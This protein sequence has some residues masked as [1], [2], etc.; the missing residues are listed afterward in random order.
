MCRPPFRILLAN[1]FI[2]EDSTLQKRV[3]DIFAHKN[4]PNV[5]TIEDYSK[6]ARSTSFW[7][8]MTG[9]T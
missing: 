5:I 2:T 1:A 7:V 8:E 3:I 6:L 4:G 9:A